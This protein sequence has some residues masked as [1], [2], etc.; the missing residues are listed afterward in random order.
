MALADA[1]I[2][3]NV[4]DSVLF[5]V[6]SG[7]TNAESARAAIDRLVSVQAQI[8]GVVLNDAKIGRRSTYGYADYQVEGAV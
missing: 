4:A 3:A 7:R 2:V 5:V 8:V 6:G 1:S